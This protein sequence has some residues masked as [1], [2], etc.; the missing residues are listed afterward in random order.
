[1]LCFMLSAISPFAAASKV[2]EDVLIFLGLLFVAVE[3]GSKALVNITL[4][5]GFSNY[6]TSNMIFS[7]ILSSELSKGFLPDKSLSA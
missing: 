7:L 2:K 6:L 1:M 4:C 3:A 5:G